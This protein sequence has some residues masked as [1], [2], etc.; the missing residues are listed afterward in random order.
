MSDQKRLPMWAAEKE[1]GQRSN[2]RW[3]VW[4][5]ARH[6]PPPDL[7]SPPWGGVLP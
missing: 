7:L 4:L 5:A 1:E 3:F 6:D 2:D